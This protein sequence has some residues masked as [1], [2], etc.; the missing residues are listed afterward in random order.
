MIATQHLHGGLQ[1]SMK[2]LCDCKLAGA[3]TVVGEGGGDRPYAASLCKITCVAELACTQAVCG[4]SPACRNTLWH[5]LRCGKSSSIHV[6][7]CDLRYI[8]AV[9]AD[10][11]NAPASMCLNVYFG[12]QAVCPADD[13]PCNCQRKC[14]QTRDR[15]LCHSVLCAS[16]SA[17]LLHSS[18][19]GASLPFP[20]THHPSG[21]DC[22]ASSLKRQIGC[23]SLVKDMYRRLAQ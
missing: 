19:R 20:C 7:P 6:S 1:G 12:V 17:N 11:A 14:R 21:L 3:S 13:R 4:C 8:Y 23:V 22:V 9:H 18:H 15:R 5:K 10:L 2:P 16:T